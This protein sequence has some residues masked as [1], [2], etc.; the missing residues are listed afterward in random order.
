[1]C[2]KNMLQYP[3]FVVVYLQQ[4]VRES[5]GNII[6]KCWQLKCANKDNGLH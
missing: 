4:E 6:D 3:Y 1:M 2:Y 5:I